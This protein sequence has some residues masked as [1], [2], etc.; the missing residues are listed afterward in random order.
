LVIGGDDGADQVVEG[1]AL[2]GRDH[3]GDRPAGVELDI[4]VIDVSADRLTDK[5]TG[6]PYHTALVKVDDEELAK[7]NEFAP[8]S[9]VTIPELEDWPISSE[10]KN[11]NAFCRLSERARITRARSAWRGMPTRFE[12]VTQ[13]LVITKIS[14][15]PMRGGTQSRRPAYTCRRNESWG[16]VCLR[17]W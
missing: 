2:L 5:R 14:A 10:E 12:V 4:D 1:G 7:T 6:T 3:Y 9:A 11:A 13:C 17:N 15:P 16:R 8:F